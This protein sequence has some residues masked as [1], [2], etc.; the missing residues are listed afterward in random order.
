MK[1][2]AAAKIREIL[3]LRPAKSSSRSFPGVN[4]KILIYGAGNCGKEVARFLENHG[5]NVA[6]F[7]DTNVSSGTLVE[8]Y[9]VRHPNDPEYLSF[10]D[11]ILVV[12]AVY[13]AGCD[14]QA[15]VGMLRQLGYL[16]T[17]TFPEF[18]SYFAEEFGPRF[19][20]SSTDCYEGREI[21]LAETANIFADQVSRDLYYS[22]LA[23]RCKA[24]YSCLPPPSQEPQ[25]FD[26]TVTRW[27]D[28]ISFVD[29]GSF[30]G[31][32][33]DELYRYYGSVE[34]I[35]A[36]EPDIGNFRVMTD[37]LRNSPH[38]YARQITAFPNG[39]WSETEM[40][41]FSSGMGA[42]S[43][44][45]L[46]GSNN[47]QAVSLDDALTNFRPSVIKMDIE[48]AEINALLGAKRI[49]Q[50]YKPKLAVCV[51][52]TPEHL[53]EI[54]S[55]LNGWDLGYRFHLRSYGFST[56]ETVLY[57]I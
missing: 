53:W 39:I 37:K 5:M 15:I 27:E 17:I 32:T 50:K 29:C 34:S 26:D 54:P 51:Y 30:T 6:G 46:S 38:Q 23:F 43:S 25:Y 45:S 22:I 47:I 55:L 35:V 18:H 14:I 11:D 24:D 41:S 42:S 10:S 21:E 8:N 28:P 20:L 2:V 3:A 52:H 12:I 44:V 56:L 33:L 36:F 7:L 48:G 4:K 16:Y 13:N 19:W 1:T 49:I 31:D 57:A 9:V 40:L